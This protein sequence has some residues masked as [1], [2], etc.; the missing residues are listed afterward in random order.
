MENVGIFYDR[1]EHFMAI[2]HN[3]RQFCVVFGHLV[4]FVHFGIFGPRK[5]WQPRGRPRKE[6]DISLQAGRR[7]HNFS[8]EKN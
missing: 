7:G 5:I 2:W 3:V 8:G 1:L 4:Y 6:V